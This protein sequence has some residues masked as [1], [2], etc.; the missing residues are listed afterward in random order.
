M[1]NEFVRTSVEGGIALV[2]VDRPPVNALNEQLQAELEQ[3]FDSLDRAEEVRAVILTGAGERAFIAGADIKML[4]GLD[5]EGAY[6]QSQYTHAVL[7]T[8]ERC[9]KVVICAVGGLALGGG[10]E[11]ALA[12]DLRVA[13]E[14]AVFGFPEVGLG[15]LPGAGGTQRLTRLI[16]A[17]RAKLLILTGDPIPASEALSLGLVEKV[18][19]KGQAVSA[20]RELAARIL[21]R[22]PVAVAHAKKAIAAATQLPPKEG[23]DAESRLFAQLFN[24]ADQKEGVTAFLEKRKPAFVGR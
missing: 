21:T 15:L 12:C 5:E 4:S 18:V 24:T 20:A 17:G 1:G 16:G 7:D 22:G 10:C 13:D 19:P 23:M 6:R 9:R 8:V 2:T 14:T 3:T 11:V